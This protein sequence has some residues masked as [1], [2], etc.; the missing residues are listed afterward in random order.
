MKSDYP[1]AVALEMYLLRK[2]IERFNANPS[3]QNDEDVERLTSSREVL[4]KSYYAT[5]FG[6]NVLPL[7]AVPG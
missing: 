5:A 3:N 1:S 6:E 7:L 4:L 2:E